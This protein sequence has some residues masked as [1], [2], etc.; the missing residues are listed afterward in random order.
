MDRNI[1]QVRATLASEEKAEF[2]DSFCDFNRPSIGVVA[3]QDDGVVFGLKGDT[4]ISI[5]EY[6]IA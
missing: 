1:P 2:P 3:R 4:A 5:L 6:T